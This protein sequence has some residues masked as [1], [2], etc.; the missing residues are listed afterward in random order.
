MSLAQPSRDPFSASGRPEF[1]WKPP[2]YE[3]KRISCPVTPP[4]TIKKPR[5]NPPV[6]HQPSPT[7]STFDA[8]IY[9]PAQLRDDVEADLWARAGEKMVDEGNGRVS[10]EDLNLTS[11]PES[12]IEVLSSFFTSSERFETDYL[13]TVTS[14]RNQAIPH[15]TRP[16][17]RASTE[18]AGAD[19]WGSLPGNNNLTHL[20]PEIVRLKGLE[21]LSLGQN[22]IHYLP[23]EILQMTLK[24]LYLI[25]NPFVKPPSSSDPRSLGSSTASQRKLPSVMP[26][27][28]PV[29]KTKRIMSRV[30]PLAELLLRALLSPAKPTA[31]GPETV[32]EAYYEL[33]LP[34]NYLETITSKK[35]DICLPGSVIPALGGHDAESTGSGLCPSPRHQRLGTSRLYVQ[36]AEERYTWE[37][38]VAGVELGGF[39]PIRWRGCELGCLDFLDPPENIAPTPAPRL[40][41]ASVGTD[42][43]HDVDS[44]VQVVQLGPRGAAEHFDDE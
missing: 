1:D 40:P 31:G 39:V 15:V 2:Q 13:T 22:S 11:I 7:Y 28:R 12:F 17:N 21:E 14:P 9:A 36:H 5:Y 27:R 20:P 29:S 18:P 10:L 34:S 25:P 26:K 4:S 35:I 43:D 23:A 33:P 41:N 6:Y 38:T 19:I 30:P 42:G 16:L 44:V 8:Q 37:T 3:K 32:L 24:A